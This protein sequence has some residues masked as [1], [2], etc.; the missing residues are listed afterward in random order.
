[1]CVCLV[2]VCVCVCVCVHVFVYKYTYKS[3][4][5]ATRGALRNLTKFTGKH[6]CQGV[7]FNKVAV[8]THANL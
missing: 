6:L 4:I 7:F 3:N 8:L 5:R 2:C 1:M